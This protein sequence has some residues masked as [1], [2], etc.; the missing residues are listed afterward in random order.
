VQRKK[1]PIIYYLC[2][3]II[4]FINFSIASA[5]IGLKIP[6]YRIEKEGTESTGLQ[7]SKPI[8]PLRNW[9]DLSD[10]YIDLNNDAKILNIYNFISPNFMPKN[11]FALDLRQSSSYI[12]RQ[13]RDELNLIMNRPRDSAFLPILPVAFIALQLAGQYL[14]VQLKTEISAI[15]IKKSRT[16][17]PVLRELWSKSPQ[18]LTELYDVA[19]IR[20]NYTMHELEKMVEILVDNKLVKRREIE[21]ASTKYFA[22]IDEKKYQEIL[23]R[24]EAKKLE[25][26]DI[27][28]PLIELK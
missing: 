2:G 22:A 13:V 4:I 23:R 7:F 11:P 28:T 5:Q 19:K 25:S 15:D 18:T 16:A 1:H 8:L 17:L 9:E 12:P 27:K 3:A 10:T 6:H 26:P 14:L 20:D 21:N 24:E